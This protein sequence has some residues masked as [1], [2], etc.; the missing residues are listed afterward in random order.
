MGNADAKQKPPSPDTP[1]PNPGTLIL[2]VIAEDNNEIILQHRICRYGI[3]QN[4]DT[5]ISW[6]DQEFATELALSFQE[7]SGCS[8]IWVKMLSDAYA[9]DT[10]HSANYK[11][12]GF[13]AVELSSRPSILEVQGIAT[14]DENDIGLQFLDILRSIL[15]QRKQGATVAEIF[16]KGHLV[17]LT[18]IIAA[19]CSEADLRAKSVDGND[20][21]CMSS[22][23]EILLRIC[24]FLCFCIQR[25]PRMMKSK[26]FLNNVL[27]K[28]LLLTKR[29]ETVLVVAAVKFFR[30]IVDPCLL[31][32]S[33]IEDR[34]GTLSDKQVMT[35]AKCQALA[36]LLP[37]LK[38][39]GHR[40]LTFSQWTS[41]LDIL[42][43]LSM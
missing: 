24:G 2:V 42:S 27:E 21:K 29:R 9:D 20:V 11:V 10:V 1:R 23:P 39:G 22:K 6:K 34:K 37:S 36:E 41:V 40:V 28:V 12:Q 4:E 33:G 3:Y 13:P 18:E 25:H 8:Y 35:S 16:F 31:F 17:Q 32:N 5:F 26:I 14:D 30:I 7:P 43:G 15:K 38:E 19:S